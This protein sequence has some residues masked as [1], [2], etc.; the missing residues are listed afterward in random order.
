MT[1]SAMD[2][3]GQLAAETKAVLV[4]RDCDSGRA[5]PLTAAECAAFERPARKP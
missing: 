2:L 3:R 5:G 1:G 4:A